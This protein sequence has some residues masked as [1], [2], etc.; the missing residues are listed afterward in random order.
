MHLWLAPID[1][2]ALVATASA[3]RALRKS[4]GAVG[5]AAAR[6]L[7]KMYR[8][9]FR[10]CVEAQDG[11]NEHRLVRA[12]RAVFSLLKSLGFCTFT[13]A[14][15]RQRTLR[16][17][18]GVPV[19]I[20]ERFRTAPTLKTLQQ[21]QGTLTA[22][23]QQSSKDL[24]Q[25]NASLLQKKR[26]VADLQREIRDIETKL[27]NAKK[28]S[29]QKIGQHESKILEAKK[30]HLEALKAKVR[31]A[32]K[33]EKDALDGQHI[34]GELDRLLQVKTQIRRLRLQGQYKD[35]KPLQQEQQRLEKETS[36]KACKRTDERTLNK[37]ESET[38]AAEEAYIE[39][40]KANMADF[41]KKTIPA[42]IKLQGLYRRHLQRNNAQRPSTAT[43]APSVQPTQLPAS[44]PPSLPSQSIPSS[45]PS[46]SI[47]PASSQ[48]NISI[49]SLGSLV[50]SLMPRVQ[51][52]SQVNA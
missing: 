28:E 37:L 8:K 48:S 38:R 16:D 10:A 43:V 3:R 1:V 25:L 9:H 51:L 22:F 20:W 12:P 26:Q 31:Q 27:E 34:C 52:K 23:T 49:R 11:L 6:K 7:H 45:S 50:Q 14:Q 2:C 47:A 24:S 5:P 17:D 41:D 30:L 21:T 19:C 35:L 13:D 32:E 4:G 39:F 42:A 15:G 46:Q 40:F 29:E 18:N 44:I 36:G 33:N